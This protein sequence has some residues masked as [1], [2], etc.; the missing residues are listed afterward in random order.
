MRISVSGSALTISNSFFAGSVSVPGLVTV[1]V[2][3]AAQADVEI[4]REQRDAVLRRFEQ[5]VGENRN[6]VLPLDD[7]LQQGKF[8]QQIVLADDKFHRQG[9]LTGCHRALADRAGDLFT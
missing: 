6:G 4:G 5:D 9:D 2:A 7:A 8:F 3:R 1:A